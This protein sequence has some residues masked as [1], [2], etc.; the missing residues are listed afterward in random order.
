M[1]RLTR[2]LRLLFRRPCPHKT[3]AFPRRYGTCDMQR[4]LD[5][6]AL[7]TSRVRFGRWRPWVLDCIPIED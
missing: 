1:R 3:L 4:C 6:G 2:I 5:C 7:V